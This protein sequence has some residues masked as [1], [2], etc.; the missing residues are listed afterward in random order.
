MLSLTEQLN[1]GP[2]VS[3]GAMATE[4]EKRGVATNSALWS[5][6]AM[7]DHPDAIQAVHQSY[8]DAGAKIMTTNTYQA[9]VPAFEQAG[10]AAA[11]AR[12]LIQQAVTI[13]HTARAA[14]HVTDAVIAGSIGPYGAYLADGSEYTGAYQL[15]PSAYQ[16]FH[17][18]RL[19]L[20][21]AAGVDVLAL[22]TMPRLDEVQALVQLITTTWPQQP[23][24]VSFSI[25]DPQTLCDGTSL[26]AAAKWVAAQPNVV[27]VGVNCTTLENIA[28]A[29]ATLKAAVAVPLIVYPNSGDQYDPVTKTWQETHLSHQF[30]SF[31]PQWLAAGARII[32]GCCRTTPKDIATVARALSVSDSAKL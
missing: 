28:P 20:I 24:W 5:A 4:L 30:A 16:D 18:E 15:T 19:A 3:D 8:L 14:S 25:K 29:L 10:I 1:R 26:A 17:R 11:Q 27:A 9:N 23:Y 21:M 31:V 7:L 12:Q 32:G 2:V 22:E 13:A 6:T